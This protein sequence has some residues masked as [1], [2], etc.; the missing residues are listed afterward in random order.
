MQRITI[1]DTD[2]YDGPVRLGWFDLDAATCVAKEDSRWDGNNMRGVISGLQI[3]RAYLYRT[4]GGR[5]VEHC[6]ASNEFN[7][8]NRWR[9]LD[10]DEAREWLMRAEEGEELLGRWFPETP[11]EVGPEPDKGGRPTVG[12]AISVAYPRDL[13]DR[14]D[15]AAQKAGQTRAQWLRKAATA[16]LERP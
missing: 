11:D 6:D 4:S 2:A 15:A 1:Y 9:F 3:N 16:M 7:G 8:P 10:E 12:P 14:I 13:L 5:W